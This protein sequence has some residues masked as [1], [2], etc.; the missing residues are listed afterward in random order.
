[1]GTLMIQPPRMEHSKPFDYIDE[2][3]D[4]V[5]YLKKRY[6]ISDIAAVEICK[7]SNTILDQAIKDEQLAGFG[8]I[9]E[10][11]NNG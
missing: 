5:V 3:A 6:G 2:I 1:M 9:L 11:L 10:G 7:L 8:E 4:Q